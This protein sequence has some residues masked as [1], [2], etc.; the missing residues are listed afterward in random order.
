MASWV[1]ERFRY[2]KIATS[3][4]PIAK[5]GTKDPLFWTVLWWV[6]AILSFGL[7]TIKMDLNVFLQMYATTI[8]PL[9]GYP[10]RFAALGK[11]LLVHECRHTWQCVMCGYLI[12]IVG[13]IPGKTGRRIRA[14]VGLLPMALIYFVLP[15]PIF[16]CYG[17]YRLELDADIKAWRWAL[18]NGYT[19]DA[20]RNR[21][22]ARIN[23][24]GGWAYGRPWPKAWVRKGY[25]TA[26]EEV[27]EQCLQQRTSESA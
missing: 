9:Q 11:R 20:T 12:P 3:I 27:I 4:E 13:W 22:A 19:V 10:R 26:V 8:G 23:T 25:L 16:F 15:F 24:V 18:E 1:F 7:I 6:G 21:A 14:W 5:V 2:Q 17:R